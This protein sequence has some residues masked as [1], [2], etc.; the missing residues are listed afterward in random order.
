MAKQKTSSIR[1][2]YWQTAAADDYDSYS[3]LINAILLAYDE[4]DERKKLTQT[5]KDAITKGDPFA[6]AKLSAGRDSKR[7][8]DFFDRVNKNQDSI[9]GQRYITFKNKMMDEYGKFD[10]RTKQTI[11]SG[12]AKEICKLL[13]Q[14]H[15]AST[16]PAPFGSAGKDTP[17]S[18]AS[19]SSMTTF[20]VVWIISS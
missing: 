5:Q 6:V 9:L 12:S 11:L 1:E 19:N 8:L 10:E 13:K 16:D 7:L 4:L 3:N 14:D 17:D 15:A 18:G 20:T 2:F